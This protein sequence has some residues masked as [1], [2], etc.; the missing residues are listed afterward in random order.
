MKSKFGF[1]PI[2]LPV[3]V[4]V[5]IIGLIN[6]GNAPWVQ[7][8]SDSGTAGHDNTPHTHNIPSNH[9]RL[10]TLAVNNHPDSADWDSEE[11][12]DLLP[13][14]VA[15]GGAHVSNYKISASYN[16]KFISV[17]ATAVSPVTLAAIK[18]TRPGEKTEDIASG[19][20]TTIPLGTTRIEVEVKQTT[21]NV[22]QVSTYRIDLTRE[23][24]QFAQ[25]VLYDGDLKEDPGTRFGLANRLSVQLTDEDDGNTD[26]DILYGS[27]TLEGNDP[28]LRDGNVVDVRVKYHVDKIDMVLTIPDGLGGGS[29]SN[30]TSD[31]LVKVDFND[32]KK[33]SVQ[34]VGAQ[35]RVVGYEL[36]GVGRNNTIPITISST[37]NV[38][39][40]YKI[41]IYRE[42]PLLE[43]V[44]HGSTP[45][46]ALKLGTTTREGK[47]SK[48]GEASVVFTTDEVTVSGQG[49]ED[50]EVKYKRSSSDIRDKD[51]DKA[52]G[53]Y[54]SMALTQGPNT[55]HITA[56]DKENDNNRDKTEYTLNIKRAATPLGNLTLESSSSNDDFDE[57]VVPLCWNDEKCAIGSSTQGFQRANTSTKTDYYASVNYDVKEIEVTATS[58]YLLDD[59]TEY[60]MTLMLRGHDTTTTTTLGAT[61]GTAPTIRAPVFALRQGPNP[62]KVK[63]EIPGPSGYDDP[64]ANS[65]TYTINVTR[66][67]PDLRPSA[68]RLIELPNG[69]ITDATLVDLTPTYS[70]DDDEV[71]Y[72]ATVRSDVTVVG[73]AADHGSP[74]SSIYVGDGTTKIQKGV[75]ISYDEFKKVLLKEDGQTVIPVKVAVDGTTNE[76]IISLV[77]SKHPMDITW[78]NEIHPYSDTSMPITVKDEEPLANPI[79]LPTASSKNG[80]VS[81]DLDVVDA[82]G[83]EVSIDD[84]GLAF[85][86]DKTRPEIDG[87]P[88]LKDGEGYESEFL[89]KYSATDAVNN[90]IVWQFVLIITHG[91]G[92]T[93]P[94]LGPGPAGPANNTLKSLAVEGKGVDGFAHDS[95]GPYDED[96]AQ[97]KKTATI[98]AVPNNS[99]A[100][101]Y[102]DGVAFDDQN[103]AITD[104]FG[105]EL[106]V[107]VTFDG[108]PDMD[109]KLTINKAELVPG[110]LSFG[111]ID[112]GHKIYVKDKKIV[113]LVLPKAQGGAGNYTYSMD[114]F[115]PGS[116][117]FAGLKFDADPNTRTLSGM[118]VLYDAFRTKYLLTYRVTDGDGDTFEDTFEMVI[119]N[120]ESALS[121]DCRSSGPD[122][123][124]GGLSLNGVSLPL[125]GATVEVPYETTMA[126]VSASSTDIDIGNVEWDITPADGDMTVTT[127]SQTVDGRV[128]AGEEVTREIALETGV[129]TIMVMAEKEYG[130][131]STDT[132]TVTVTRAEA[133]ANP[134]PKPM[135]LTV[136]RDGASAM[137]SWTPG[138]DSSK[139]AVV[140]LDPSNLIASAIATFAELGADEDS[141]TI[142]GLTAGVN[143]TYIVLGYDSDG[144]YKDADGNLYTATY[145]GGS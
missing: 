124:L 139:Q 93:I 119:C 56:Y 15:D 66:E 18:V 8:H 126:T 77:V 133:P 72:T 132:Y 114:S 95:V 76:L 110:D 85:D 98:T 86:D 105:K 79:V 65:Q 58:E 118:P 38:R 34:E 87:T 106:I 103:N 50:V 145:M 142:S 9:P 90:R 51:D 30:T 64:R 26:D 117:P 120:P 31:D 135:G 108:L 89:V 43:G 99:D 82:E 83:N 35:Y 6:I 73:V 41:V 52:T 20:T 39:T 130:S 40:D 22:S 2:V 88:D 5:L 61:E 69:I 134:G 111:M 48:S 127:Y 47:I 81:Y 53:W 116:V 13:A 125:A 122:F 143:Y 112:V 7:A 144:N 37:T 100:K 62:I 115:N 24:P 32:V 102:L 49:G 59:T 19:A 46:P 60:K 75:L 138:A 140:A 71:V 109:Y 74:L 23:K 11:A 96:V 78:D 10:S 80:G 104:T 91:D 14:F 25:L 45:V 12:L 36:R 44:S 57:D 55:L 113:D 94:P 141:Y 123:E 128:R 63:V 1:I 27:H 16:V 131:T 4:M 28:D 17:D 33:E 54:D 136:D 68:L 70:Q 42:K 29:G 92:D 97:A 137:L 3:L 101:V 84:L 129:N 121:R 67:N 107:K 21:S